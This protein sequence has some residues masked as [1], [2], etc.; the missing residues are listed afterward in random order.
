MLLIFPAEVTLPSGSTVLCHYPAIVMAHYQGGSLVDFL[1]GSAAAPTPQFHWI[2]L[3]IP[4]YFG[5][6]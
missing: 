3:V 1:K 5:S 4:P 2:D 6:E